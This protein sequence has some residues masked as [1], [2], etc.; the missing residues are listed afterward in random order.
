MLLIALVLVALTAPSAAQTRFRTWAL[1]V[2]SVGEPLAAW[3][4]ELAY[5]PAAVKIVGV[6]GGRAPWQAAP[7]YDPKGLE[8]GRLVVAAFTLAP[9]P[10]PGVTR[11]AR[12]HAQESGL[13]EHFIRVKLT[14]AADPDGRRIG[15]TV[16]LVPEEGERP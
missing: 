12:I 16:R 15:A 2:D 3:Q 14:A 13:G 1:I 8:A 5:D 11:V 10:P 9:Y 7:H 6:E 4:V